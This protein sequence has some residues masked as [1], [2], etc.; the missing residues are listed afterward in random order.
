VGDIIWGWVVGR[1]YARM[2]IQS[3]V[4]KA[5]E[6][7]I[8]D[9]IR[10]PTIT[11]RMTEKRIPTTKTIWT[12]VSGCSLGAGHVAIASSGGFLYMVP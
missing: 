1:T 5:L 9:S 11:V 7:K 12:R 3:S 10:R 6:I 4:A 8:R 2:V